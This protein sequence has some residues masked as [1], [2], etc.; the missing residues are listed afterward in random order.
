M[1]MIQSC[2]DSSH[3][4]HHN[5]LFSLIWRHLTPSLRRSMDYFFRGR[6]TQLTYLLKEAWQLLWSTRHLCWCIKTHRETP[7]LTEVKEEKKKL[8]GQNVAHLCMTE[9]R[10]NVC[11][12]PLLSQRQ[13]DHNSECRF[14]LVDDSRSK[15]EVVPPVASGAGVPEPSQ[16]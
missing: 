2:M 11:Q 12:V 14:Y 1:V 7:S 9:N 8:W 6:K 15:V 13:T 3:V 16:D 10:E 4:S 5:I